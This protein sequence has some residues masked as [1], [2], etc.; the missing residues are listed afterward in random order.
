MA[1]NRYGH[2]VGGASTGNGAGGFWHADLFCDGA[3]GSGFSAR[4]A[5]QGFPNAALEGGGADVE[6][7]GWVRFFSGDQAFE[8]VVPVGHGF[9]VSAA[10]GEWKFAHQALR[11][12]LVGGG[13]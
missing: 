11:Q 4:D 3:V 9:V 2:R 1:W 6:G 12:F 13:E 10:G 7:E 5:L 8:S